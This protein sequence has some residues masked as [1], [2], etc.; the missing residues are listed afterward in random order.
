M[1]NK[2][3]KEKDAT[4][5]TDQCPETSTSPEPISA[6]SPESA[7]AQQLG[8]SVVSDNTDT[9]ADQPV[10]Q[11]DNGA[12]AIDMVN[13]TS[14]NPTPDSTSNHYP[15]VKHGDVKFTVFEGPPGTRLTKA[16]SLD[17]DDNVTTASAPIFISGSARTE[18]ITRLTDLEQI[19]HVLG[20]NECI[21]T[22]IFDR[23]HCE[24]ALKADLTE[25]RIA[26]GVRARSLELMS[27]PPPGLVLLD[28][29]PSPRM[30]EHMHC[31][32]PT[33]LMEKLSSIS[34]LFEGIGYSG[35]GSASNG[36]INIKTGEP[37]TKNG[38][39]CYILTTETELRELRKWLRVKCWLAGIIETPG[40]QGQKNKSL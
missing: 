12:P 1:Y 7:P 26:A 3:L 24:I 16:L 21:A 28:F 19:S 34:P 35:A 15:A 9:R 32:S 27:Q 22:G 5:K 11:K 39:H 8:A 2:E 17:G 31:A 30:P 23:S 37:H 4:P 33:D 13:S 14:P 38:F 29:D 40:S 10:D 20:P 36:I 6:I 18:S 25:D